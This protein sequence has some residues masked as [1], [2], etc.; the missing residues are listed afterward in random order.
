TQPTALMLL[1]ILGFVPDD[2]EAHSIVQRLMAGL[3][4]GSYLVHKDGT[5]TSEKLIEASR[6][7]N[8]TGAIPYT[9]RDLETLARNFDGLEMVEP[10]LVD[11]TQW[12]PE[13][14]PSGVRAPVHEVCGVARKP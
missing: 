13:P 5:P 2:D 1:G 9:L 12:R 7:Y 14:D 11:V 4:S 6:H 3:P 8:E 10:G